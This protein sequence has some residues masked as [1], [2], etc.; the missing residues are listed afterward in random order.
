MK[1]CLGSSALSL[2]QRGKSCS[3]L[4]AL[5]RFVGLLKHSQKVSAAP[6]GEH[7]TAFTT[8]PAK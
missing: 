5:P 3:E 4:P 7:F 2:G 6:Q 1:T 8:L